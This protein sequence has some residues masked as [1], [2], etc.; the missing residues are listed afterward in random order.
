LQPGFQNDGTQLKEVNKN[1]LN[2]NEN[3]SIQWLRH[4]GQ[5]EF[6]GLPPSWESQLALDTIKINSGAI[7]M[8]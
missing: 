6:F 8:R 7:W 3:A 5:I 4:Q 2:G 1:R